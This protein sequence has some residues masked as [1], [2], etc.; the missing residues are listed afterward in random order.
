MNKNLFKFPSPVICPKCGE[1]YLFYISKNGKRKGILS[2]EY[3]FEGFFDFH[4]GNHYDCY[5]CGHHWDNRASKKDLLVKIL[6]FL[7][8][9]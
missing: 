8:N 1:K 3:I 6:P 5:T 9:K 2:G 4:Y 7:E